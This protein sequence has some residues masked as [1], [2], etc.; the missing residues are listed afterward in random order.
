MFA[1]NALRSITY[2]GVGEGFRENDGIW[3]DSSIVL[4]FSVGILVVVGNNVDAEAEVI[5][6]TDEGDWTVD[7]ALVVFFFCALD[8]DLLDDEMAEEVTSEVS[9]DVV[10]EATDVV[11]KAESDEDVALLGSAVEIIGWVVGNVLVPVWGATAGT[12][13]FVETG[14]FVEADVC[15]VAESTEAVNADVLDISISFELGVS[16][17]A[18]GSGAPRISVAA[19]VISPPTRAV[20]G[21]GSTIELTAAVGSC[22]TIELTAV[23]GSCSITEPI[24]SAPAPTAAVCSGS[25]IPATAPATST[26]AAVPTLSTTDT[27]IPRSTVTAA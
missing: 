10:P 23:V 7:Q 26:P 12:A 27:A 21:N 16:E 4:C 5:V 11:A 20:V 14:R 2:V 9:A 18:V 6:L 15:V 22:S 1:G 24:I 19:L 25:T 3:N 13:E 17:T 8:P